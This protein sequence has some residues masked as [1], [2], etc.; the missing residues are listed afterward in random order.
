MHRK[1]EYDTKGAGTKKGEVVVSPDKQGDK[2]KAV[3][4][5]GP[6]VRLLEPS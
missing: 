2:G 6:S 1:A 5:G 4:T 3:S